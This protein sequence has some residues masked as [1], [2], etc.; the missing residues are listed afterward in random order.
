MLYTTPLGNP[1]K[2]AGTAAGKDNSVAAVQLQKIRRTP[3]FTEIQDT[4]TIN[5]K[6]SA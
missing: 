5:R 2:E 6:H 4:P 3:D 1:G